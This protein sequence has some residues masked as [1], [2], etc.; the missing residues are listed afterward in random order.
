MVS[1]EYKDVENKLLLLYLINRMEL[2]MSRA[3]IT[4]FVMQK[5]FINYFVLE[6]ALSELLELGLLECTEINAQDANTTRYTLTQQGETCLEYFENHIPRP[7]RVVINQYV[8]ENR[9]KV[10][11][12]Y[13][14]TAT[15]FPDAENDDFRVKCGVY[16]DM[17]ALLEISVSVDTREQAKAIQNNWRGNASKLYQRIIDVVLNDSSE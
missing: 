12:D 9:G 7:V 5:E 1:L 16:E 13:E 8:E 6:Q 2:S 10:R 17:R 3:Q 15:Y 4:E 11:R 14:V